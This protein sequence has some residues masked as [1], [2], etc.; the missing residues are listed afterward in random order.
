[1]ARGPGVSC[2]AH[3]GAAAAPPVAAAAA[4]AWVRATGVPLLMA[5]QQMTLGQAA[6]RSAGIIAATCVA[7]ALG[8]KLLDAV[9]SQVR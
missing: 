3:G 4:Q 1:M 2:A 8:N 6:V 5:M 7:V 9:G